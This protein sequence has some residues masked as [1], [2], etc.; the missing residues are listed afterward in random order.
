MGW[1]GWARQAQLQ[2]PRI[3]MLLHPTGS[4]PQ[5]LHN[6]LGAQRV[7]WDLRPTHH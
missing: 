1:E 5:N 4:Y 3:L 7:T 6:R 2:V